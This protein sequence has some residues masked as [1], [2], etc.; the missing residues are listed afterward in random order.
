[1]KR[2]PY[3]NIER[4]EKWKQN[5]R[6]G[7]PEISKANSEVI[8]EYLRDME[9]GLNIGVGSSKGGRAPSRLNDLKVK[10]IFFAKQLEQLFNISDLRNITEEQ[11]FEFF[12]ELQS[13]KIKTERGKTYKCIDTFARD[14]KSFW[15]WYIKSSRKRGKEISNIIQD[16]EVSKEK[17]DWVYLTEEQ[18][19]ELAD[20][21]NFDYKMLIYFL[22]DTGIRPPSELI[23]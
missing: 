9:L 8:L 13:G 15:N 11:L 7:I 16:L 4:W 2:D 22:Y 6:K 17:P 20:A 19:R 10:L 5:V 1:M 21:S 12:R 18:V 3:N 23:T 14:F